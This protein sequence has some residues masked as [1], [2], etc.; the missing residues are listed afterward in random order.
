MNTDGW[1][2]PSAW[3]CDPGELAPDNTPAVFECAP[4]ASMAIRLQYRREVLEQSEE[5]LELWC[6]NYERR[7]DGFV[8]H[9]RK[10]RN[11][12]KYLDEDDLGRAA[13]M[14][15]EIDQAQT[16]K[17]FRIV[18]AEREPYKGCNLVTHAWKLYGPPNPPS[19]PKSERDRALKP[20]DS[21]AAWQ[22]SE[23]QCGGCGTPT[24]SHSQR[25]R[26]HRK[27]KNSSIRFDMTPTYVQHD[28]KHAPLWNQ[29][30]IAAKG[31]ADHVVA[32]SQGGQTI[33]ANLTNTCA[34]CNYSKGD[35]PLEAMRVAD[36][37]RPAAETD[38]Q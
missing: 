28:G 24:I 7:W 16:D 21:N 12:V 37:R 5:E 6:N 2:F 22:R 17:D 38:P 15:N 13:L 23:G 18:L 32:R 27:M 11:I 3:R 10:M 26:L 31:V 20:S 25:D 1:K 33:V 36:Y 8:A 14:W 34:G 9:A 30:T 4:Y 35:V 29:A 19:V